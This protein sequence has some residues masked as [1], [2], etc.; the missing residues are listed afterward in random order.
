MVSHHFRAEVRLHF[1]FGREWEGCGDA[2]PLGNEGQCPLGSSWSRVPGLVGDAGPSLPP[3]LACGF[4]PFP[5]VVTK[6]R[7]EP[8]A[9]PRGPGLWGPLPA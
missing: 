1:R 2:S 5:E 8:E 9:P 3:A 4:G 7:R 6:L